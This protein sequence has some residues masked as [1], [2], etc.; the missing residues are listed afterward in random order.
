MR[1]LIFSFNGTLSDLMGVFCELGI[2]LSSMPCRILSRSDSSSLGSRY[3]LREEELNSGLNSSSKEVRNR[4][5][6]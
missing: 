3:K 6:L 2:I 1:S 5:P 4:E